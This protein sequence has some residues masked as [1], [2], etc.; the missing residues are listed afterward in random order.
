MKKDT[1]VQQKIWN[2]IDNN[3][4][5]EYANRIW[6]MH[7]DTLPSNTCASCDA[8]KICHREKD[9]TIF[10]ICI[11]AQMESSLYCNI[12]IYNPDEQDKLDNYAG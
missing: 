3:K 10:N 1:L 11:G 6:M 8:Q 12:K 2:A 7:F 5:F 9:K 4:P